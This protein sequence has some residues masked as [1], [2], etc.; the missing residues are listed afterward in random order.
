VNRKMMSDLFT[1]AGYMLPNT[2]TLEKENGKE[3]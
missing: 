1:L 3:T 2:K